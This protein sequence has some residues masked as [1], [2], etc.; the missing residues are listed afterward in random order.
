L[1]EGSGTFIDLTDTPASYGGQALL[2]TRVNSGETALEFFDPATQAELVSHTGTGN[3]HHTWPLTDTEIPDTHTHDSSSI[4][5]AA[6]DTDVATQSELDTHAADVDNHIGADYYAALAGTYGSPASGNKYVTGNDAPA[7]P[8]ASRVLRLNSDGSIILPGSTWRIGGGVALDM[9]LS[10]TTWDT[11][12]ECQAV[13]M[14][15]SE[16]DTPFPDKLVYSVVGSW[17]HT[18]NQGWGPSETV[19][20]Q[21]PG[22]IIPL[23]R[24]DNWELKLRLYLP[25]V[26]DAEEGRLMFGYINNSN[27][28]GAYGEFSDTDGSNRRVQCLLYTNDG[29][30]TFTA[31]YTGTTSDLVGAGLRY[32]YFRCQNGCVG[33]WDDKDDAWH[34]YEGRQSTTVGYTAA[35]IFLQAQ[36]VGA[37]DLFVYQIYEL[38]LTYLT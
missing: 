28:V 14:R 22:I 20:D 34:W 7:T 35:A 38:V 30:D 3:A 25:S 24:P 15:F 11:Q 23:M 19:A 37:A 16:S 5:L 12:A 31:R 21:G 9:S 18:A 32:Y 27:Q 10:T 26:P 1:V 8:A 17:L 2:A 6:L 36:Q 33:V 29:D 13:G 4:P